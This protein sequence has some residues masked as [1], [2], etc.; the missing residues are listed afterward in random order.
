MR[1]FTF[2]V[3]GLVAALSASAI[4]NVYLIGQATP[5]GW[6]AGDAVPMTAEGNNVFTYTGTFT[7]GE[8][9]FTCV[10][11]EWF[12]RI[13]AVKAGII[14]EPGKTY[15]VLYGENDKDPDAPEDFKFYIYA[16][17]YSLTLTMS[18][19]DNTGTLAITG[20]PDPIVLPANAPEI[21]GSMEPEEMVDEGDGIYSYEGFFLKND[22]FKFRYSVEWWP[23]IVAADE[24]SNVPMRPRE[25]VK[26]IYLPTIYEARDHKFFF[27]EEGSHKIFLDTNKMIVYIDEEPTADNAPAEEQGFK[28]RVVITKDGY[29]IETEKDIRNLNGVIIEEK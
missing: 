18:S 27:E 2:L 25:A 20:T 19:E 3:L 10:Q 24:T 17:T 12:P 11:G 28:N 29:V 8:F 16:G 15:D 23:G 5:A 9:K 1:K 13:V 6:S 21:C 7:N 22:D 26:A 14:V 4:E